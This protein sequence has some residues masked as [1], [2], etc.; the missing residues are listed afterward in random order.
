VSAKSHLE[1]THNPKPVECC[2]CL[3]V[4]NNVVA[5]R[6]HILRKHGIRGAKNLVQHY[7]RIIEN[8]QQLQPQQ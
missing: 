7:G 6:M 5:F 3:K 4:V 2:L 8:Q 1:H